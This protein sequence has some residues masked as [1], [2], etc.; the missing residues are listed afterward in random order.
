M[1]LSECLISGELEEYKW[2]KS[3]YSPEEI[4]KVILRSRSQLNPKSKNFWTFFYK[5]D[6][7]GV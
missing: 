4:K 1:L 7:N 5:L 2:L 3:V 6:N